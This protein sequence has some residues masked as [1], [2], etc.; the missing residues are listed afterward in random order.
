ML[1]ESGIDLGLSRSSM[2]RIFN[3]ARLRA[4]LTVTSGAWLQALPISSVSLHIDDDVIKVAMDFCLG[5]NLCASDLQHCVARDAARCHQCAQMPSCKEPA[6]LG[7]SD[8]KRPDGVSLIPWSQGHCVSWDVT[9]LNTLAPFYLFSSTIQAGSAAVRAEVADTLKYSALATHIFVTLA[10]ETL[11]AWAVEATTFGT[12]LGRR[13]TAV[14]GDP[15]DTAFLRQ[16]LMMAI[17]RG[18][19]YS[20]IFVIYGICSIRNERSFQAIQ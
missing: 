4:S 10:F 18:K 13:M 9:S 6:G 16:C 11:G 8:R 2:T 19:A 12:E 20:K 1:R 5:A 17:Q 15:R 3:K 7:R 14:T